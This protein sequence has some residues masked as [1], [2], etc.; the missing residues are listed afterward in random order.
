MAR[1]IKKTFCGVHNENSCKL[2]LSINHHFRSFGS[3]IV[4]PI[5][6]FLTIQKLC[7]C[8]TECDIKKVVNVMILPSKMGKLPFWQ[9]QKIAQKCQN[10]KNVKFIIFCFK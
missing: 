5:A 4:Y 3:I 10:L 2:S 1:V 7:N 8:R 6:S 9:Y